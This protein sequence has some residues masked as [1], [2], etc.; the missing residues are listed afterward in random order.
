[1][2]KLIYD[3]QNRRMDCG[4]GDHPIL[5]EPPLYVGPPEQDWPGKGNPHV[6]TVAVLTLGDRLTTRIDRTALVQALNPRLMVVSILRGFDFHRAW[7]LLHGPLSAFERAGMVVLDRQHANV[8]GRPTIVSGPALVAR[9][10]RTR[11]N[12]SYSYHVEAA[13]AVLGAQLYLCEKVRS[14]THAVRTRDEA[15][16]HLTHILRPLRA[17]LRKQSHG[18]VFRDDEERS[19]NGNIGYDDPLYRSLLARGS[20]LVE[21]LYAG[22]LKKA[23]IGRR[24]TAMGAELPLDAI[25]G[26]SIPW[27]VI[28]AERVLKAAVN[29]ACA[30]F[31]REGAAR[32]L[33]QEAGSLIE[34]VQAYSFGQPDAETLFEDG[35]RGEDIPDIFALTRLAWLWDINPSDFYGGLFPWRLHFAAARF[36]GNLS[37]GGEE[38]H[39]DPEAHWGLQAIRHDIFDDML[40]PSTAAARAWMR[41]FLDLGDDFW[42]LVPRALNPVDGVVPAWRFRPK[43]TRAKGLR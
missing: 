34:G 18:A 32:S 24:W 39:L 5:R 26:S 3:H 29:M 31:R 15:I 7:V 23:E 17:H 28:E 11:G 37:M 8:V 42:D 13:L 38:V 36:L 30:A 35:V 22:D 10:H 20:R 14:G 43:R 1:M 12:S 25:A 2:S 4:Y 40:D 27:A 19:A 9:G 16:E 33:R 6:L 21:D 41:P